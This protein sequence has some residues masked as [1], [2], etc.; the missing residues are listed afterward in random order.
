MAGSS[1]RHRQRAQPP[2]LEHFTAAA[3]TGPANSTADGPASAQLPTPAPPNPQADSAFFTRLPSEVRRMIYVEVWRTFGQDPYGDND[4]SSSGAE[5]ED[6]E[7]RRNEHSTVGEEHGG[8][9]LREGGLAPHITRA[10][11]PLP[12]WD[13]ASPSELP[14]NRS[15]SS[16]SSSQPAALPWTQQPTAFTSAPCFLDVDDDDDDDTD[17]LGGRTRSRHAGGNRKMPPEVRDLRPAKIAAAHAAD[18]NAPAVHRSNIGGGRGGGGRTN[19]AGV[20]WF[21]PAGQALSTLWRRRWASAWHHH[22]LCEEYF[23]GAGVSEGVSEGVSAEASTGAVLGRA[24]RNSGGRPALDHVGRRRRP[25]L[26]RPFLPILLTCRRAYVEGIDLLYRRLTFQFTDMATARAFVTRWPCVTSV[27]M[28]LQLPSSVL[29]LYQADDGNG[30]ALVVGGVG[31][32]ARPSAPISAT[33]NLWHNL[34]SALAP[35]RLPN[36]RRLHIWIESHDLRSWDRSAAEARV[37]AR[38]LE[39]FASPPPSSSSSSSST[40]LVSRLARDRFV[41][42]LPT[43]PD[44]A[45]AENPGRFLVEHDEAAA[46]TASGVAG[47]PPP[48]CF[49]DDGHPRG[50][51]LPFTVV[52]T[53]RPDNWDMHLNTRPVFLNRRLSI[54][55]RISLRPQGGGI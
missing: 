32:Q 7:N 21:P 26:R 53:P 20:L 52:R 9:C 27:R 48:P 8:P 18:L 46:L 10:M 15:R 44:K 39:L 4:A 22:W 51:A 38:L 2:L 23:T 35:A 41:L 16:S 1:A 55:S 45:V 30:P 25:P 19:E 11:A 50:P 47:P 33:N 34:C 6:G 17:G 54:G 37:F 29:D 24:A 12:V 13:G 5:G 43:L 49:D 14:A 42:Y 36:L 31:G 40:G 28:V 3:S